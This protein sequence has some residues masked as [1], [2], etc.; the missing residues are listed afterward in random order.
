M[1]KELPP[2][3]HCH[4]LVI[5]Q[6]PAADHSDNHWQAPFE[7]TDECYILKKK[8]SD[9]RGKVY[10]NTCLNSQ[11]MF[12]SGPNSSMRLNYFYR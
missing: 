3:R 1:M 8:G 5:T 12:L 4:Q 11:Q 10:D 2:D 9:I 6:R 7:E